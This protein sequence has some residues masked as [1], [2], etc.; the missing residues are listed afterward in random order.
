MP[1][2]LPDP[3]N[4]DQSVRRNF[5]ALAALLPLATANIADDAVTSAKLASGAI[6]DGADLRIVAGCVTSAGAVLFNYGGLT[7]VSHDATGKWTV[8]LATPF[9]S[10][11]YVTMLTTFGGASGVTEIWLRGDVSY[12]SSQFGVG[13]VD[14]G[15]F[16]DTTFMFACLGPR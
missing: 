7:S 5:E 10:S 1:L 12:T 11:D 9:A 6:M 16:T 4:A 14:G 3:Y 13:T 2:P 8:T 15:A